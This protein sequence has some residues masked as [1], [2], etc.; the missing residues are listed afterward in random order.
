MISL[1]IHTGMVL[2]IMK[3]QDSDSLSLKTSSIQIL[4]DKTPNLFL[5]VSK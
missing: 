1:E 3:I 4:I 5:E 2:K